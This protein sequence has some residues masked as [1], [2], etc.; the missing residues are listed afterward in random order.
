M[1]LDRWNS[2]Y[3]DGRL[4]PAV[5]AE[6]AA[7]TDASP[8]AQALADR[9]FRLM[10]RAR[11]GAADF[12]GLTAWMIGFSAPRTVP[13]AWSG[14]VPPVTMSGRHGKIDS[15]VAGNPWHT[16]VRDAVFVDLGCG[17][18]PF[19]TIDTAK[20]LPTWRVIGVD[21]AFGDYLVYDHAGAYAS[22]AADRR[23]LYYQAGNYEPDQAAT[24]A[25]FRALLDSLLDGSAS[26]EEGEL[27][28]DPVRQYES[29]NLTLARG[30]IGEFT[31]DGGADVIRCMN[32][33]MYFDH[34]FRERALEW[35]SSV[36][37]PGGL[38]ICGSNW[39]ESVA[40]RYTV[41]QKTASGLV[42]REF[43]FS[44]ENLRPI[45]LAPWYALHDDNLENLANASAVGTIRADD[46]FRERFDTRMDALLADLGVCMRGPDGYLGGA[47]E[48]MPTEELSGLS[49]VLAAR[50]DAEGFASDAA[51]VLRA[52]GYDAWRNHVGHVAMRP[53]TPPPLEPG[54]VTG[55]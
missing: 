14:S 37:R 28:R 19:T 36:L 5:L 21:P 47:P 7:L 8:D 49:P 35:A 48:G 2:A 9:A 53:V 12:S 32:V 10:R 42:A 17:F 23:L 30:G 39:T 51:E 43:A 44:V 16:P 41:Y 6:L 3:F 54:L 45:E 29:D 31:V 38:F 1:I 20:R 15:Y 13:S 24:S 55:R 52:A 33:F 25:R 50:L 40:S 22:F 27:V 4:S 34:P 26:A 18:P 11:V 46:E